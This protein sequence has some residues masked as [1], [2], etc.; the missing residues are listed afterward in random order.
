[1][2]TLDKSKP[3]GE[4]FGCP[5]VAFDQDGKH[6]NSEGNQVGGEPDAITDEFTPMTRDELI[7]WLVAHGE[8]QYN[9]NGTDDD[10]RAVCREVTA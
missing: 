4:V 2:A 1:M 5:G 10:L 6:F 9:P 8:N 7:A 3:Y